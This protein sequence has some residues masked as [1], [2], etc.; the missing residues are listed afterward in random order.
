MTPFREYFDEDFDKMREQIKRIFEDIANEFMGLESNA[1]PKDKT[2]GK[3]FSFGIDSII[4]PDGIPHI[5]TFRRGGPD[6]ETQNWPSEGEIGNDTELYADVATEQDEEW[7]E[8]FTDIMESPTDDQ[9]TVIM[10]MPGV[11][12]E[13]IK[14]RAGKH[15]L[16][17]E[18]EGATRKYRKRLQ[19]N[20][21]IDK[22]S[23]KARYRNGVLELKLQSTKPEEQ[24]EREVP[25]K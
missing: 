6:E 4:G 11:S 24:D 22:N 21:P 16:T 8:P 17:V 18:A 1:S 10:E 19:L 20:N 25:I 13:Q 5:R 14:L 9:I 2:K 12:K 23:V 3:S 15:R 7:E